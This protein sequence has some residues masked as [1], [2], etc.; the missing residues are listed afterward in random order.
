MLGSREELDARECLKTATNARRPV[1]AVLGW[2]VL[3]TLM[4]AR[5]RADALTIPYSGAKSR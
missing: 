5:N 1:H 3:M 2:D 4:F